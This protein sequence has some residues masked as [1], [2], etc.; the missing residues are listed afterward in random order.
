M[1]AVFQTYF[2]NLRVNHGVS[3]LQIVRDDAIL[4]EEHCA[5][6]LSEEPEAQREDTGLS[7]PT[8]KPSF[9][10]L[11]SREMCV[12]MIEVYILWPTEA[13]GRGE[14]IPCMR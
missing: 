12:V 2:D 7:Q 10:G 3:I 1:T 13:N 8:R 14:K 5:E 4:G 11:L 9:D 6:Q